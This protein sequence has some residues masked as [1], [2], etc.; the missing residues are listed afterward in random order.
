[1][2]ARAVTLSIGDGIGQ[3]VLSDPPL[4]ILT[5]AVLGQIRT[6]LRELET[7]KSLRVVVISAEGKHF[8]VGADVGEHLP[9]HHPDL[10]S[11]F[12]DTVR[13][14]HGF[15][16]PVLAAVRGRCLGAGFELVVAADIVIAGEDASFGQPEIML[17]VFPPAACAM[18]P[19]NCPQGM[20][21]ELIFTGDPV[22]AR[23]AQ[24]AGIVRHVVPDERVEEEAL[25]LA[26][27]IARHSGAV[28]RHTK[29]ALR[30]ESMDR[31]DGALQHAGHIY[32]AELMETKDAIEGLQAFLEKRKPVWSNE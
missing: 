19:D 14:V 26:K 4:N 28:L 22:D 2:N 17:G 7:E 15:P 11:E 21:A 18:L 31:T 20:A 5:R 10:I 23:D 32:V 9:P 12:L 6:C 29:H 25:D 27:R 13:A 3:L 30:H 8:S 24:R 1:M 16:L